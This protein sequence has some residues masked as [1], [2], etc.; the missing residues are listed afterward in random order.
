VDGTDAVDTSH[1]A[2]GLSSG[3]STPEIPA[4]EVLLA[5]WVDSPV[6][7]LPII[8]ASVLDEAFVEREIMS[9]AV[10]PRAVVCHGVVRVFAG[11]GAVYLAKQK[12]LLGGFHNGIRNESNVR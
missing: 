4:L 9:D 12:S 3:L 2:L 6:V 1:A 8:R 10:L 7:A 5:G 11:D